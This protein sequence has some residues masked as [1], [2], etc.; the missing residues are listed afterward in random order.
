MKGLKRGLKAAARSM[1]FTSQKVMLV[2]FSRNYF[3]HL[4]PGTSR[5]ARQLSISC[6]NSLSHLLNL[7]GVGGK[8][9]DK[10]KSKAKNPAQKKAQM[11]AL[12]ERIFFTDAEQLASCIDNVMRDPWATPVKERPQRAT[13]RFLELTVQLLEH[14]MVRGARIISFLSGPATI[15]KGRV[16]TLPKSEF[17]R[18]AVDLENNNKEVSFLN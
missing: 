6:S 5:L 8:D 7:L 1:D 3:L 17:M 13:G 12:E 14:M 18:K 16:A 10:S 15:S 9:N 11:I 2:S 4:N